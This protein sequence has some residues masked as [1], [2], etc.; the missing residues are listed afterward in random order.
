MVRAAATIASFPGM[1][2]GDRP[3]SYD[4]I[5]SEYATNVDSAPFNALYE[6]P[7][8]LGLLPQ[9]KGLRILD[10]GCGS[11]WYAERLIERGALVDAV[12]GSASMVE[13]A[14]A[15]L[16]ALPPAAAGRISVRFA[17]LGK[18]LPFDTGTFD[19]AISPLVLHYLPDWRPALREIHRVLGPEGWLQFSTHH[20]AADAARFGT[21]DYLAVERVTD[22]WDWIGEVTFYR[23]PLSE[24]FDSL[25]DAGF[26][27]ERVVEPVPTDEFRI[28]RPDA[29]REVMNRPEFLIIVARA[30]KTGN[31]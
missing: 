4:A 11:G 8:M 5:A 6:R 26:T 10:A 31:R 13:F 28:A 24:I 23:R 22:H 20:P 9:V 14:R 29:W 25:R 18:E 21:R 7:A 30:S 17:D 12:D 16:A 3:F 27:V 19:G 15:R 2:S 1:T